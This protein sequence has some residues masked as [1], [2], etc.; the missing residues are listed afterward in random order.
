MSNVSDK[1]NYVIL[2]I[3]AEATIDGGHCECTDKSFDVPVWMS[4]VCKS[5]MPHR[6]YAFLNPK[7]WQH[8]IKKSI[9]IRCDDTKYIL[10]IKKSIKCCKHCDEKCQPDWKVFKYLHKDLE[11]LHSKIDEECLNY[12]IRFNA[13]GYD[14][15]N[16][17]LKKITKQVI[18][19]KWACEVEK[20][21]EYKEKFAEQYSRTY[22]R[23]SKITRLHH[24]ILILLNLV[25]AK[26]D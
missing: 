7:V 5:K 26:N 8:I 20:N 4:L 17:C 25:E 9:F 18:D 22:H 3:K 23:L 14:G 21:G 11:S 15:K 19:N 12:D 10:S 13:L 6:G 1:Y 16:S 2:K 24:S